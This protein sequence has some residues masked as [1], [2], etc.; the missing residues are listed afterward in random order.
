MEYVVAIVFIGSLFAVLLPCSA[1][2]RVVWGLCVRILQESKIREEYG[3]AGD[4]RVKEGTH[5]V[6][7]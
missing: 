5:S 2:Q 4:Q 1:S 6:D 7:S 3:N